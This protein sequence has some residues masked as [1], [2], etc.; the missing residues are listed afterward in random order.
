M[1]ISPRSGDIAEYKSE[2]CE[3]VSYADDLITLQPLMGDE[4]QQISFSTEDCE[5]LQKTR[6]FCFTGENAYLGVSADTAFCL[7]PLRERTEAMARRELMEVLDKA[8]TNGRIPNFTVKILARIWAQKRN[9][10]VPN[11]STVRNWHARWTASGRDIFSLVP[12]YRTRGN[13]TARFPFEVEQIMAE[14]I[15]TFYLNDNRWTKSRAY[16]ALV[17][18][19]RVANEGRPFELRLPLPS[20]KAFKRRIADLDAY[21][22]TLRR[23][24][25]QE[26]ER[27]HKAAKRFTRTALYPNHI[28]QVDATPLDIIAVDPENG[29]ALTRVWMTV[30]IDQFSRA[31][32]GYYLSYDKSDYR[33]IAKALMIGISDKEEL[34]ERF[35]GL[36]GR[37]LCH[38]RPAILICDNAMENHSAAFSAMCATKGMEIELIYTARRHPQGKPHVE[39]VIRTINE[40]FHGVP[41]TTHS[42]PQKRGAYNSKKHACL[43]FEDIEEELLRFIVDIYHVR[44]HRSLSRPPQ[45]VWEAGVEEYRPQLPPHDLD[46]KFVYMVEGSRVLQKDGIHFDK[47]IYSGPGTE[48]LW[49]QKGRISVRFRYDPDIRV[50]INVIHPETGDAM[51]ARCVNMPEYAEKVSEKQDR[52]FRQIARACTGEL[53]QEQKIARAYMDSYEHAE[54]CKQENHKRKRSTAKASRKPKSGPGRSKTAPPAANPSET[55]E[56]PSV[57]ASI[58]ASADDDAWGG[59]T[60]LLDIKHR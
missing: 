14:V 12:N 19:I 24:G 22:V 48:E 54:A 47:S 38:G 50:S 45:D 55:S 56:I 18:V 60:D 5:H 52:K 57:Y 28:W 10:E 34:L 7:Q 35:P 31:I 44:N 26:A 4:S 2:L 11:H 13:R 41:G 51:E 59:G 16:Y 43:T 46:L 8:A 40:H 27:I 20:R 36:R 30:I 6:E 33:S 17:D 1:F 15:D 53:T 25:R 42:N 39:R 32:V 29:E 49:K 3:V 9:R 37:W 21:Y 23:F 58:P